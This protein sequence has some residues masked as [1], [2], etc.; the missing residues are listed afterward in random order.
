M[1]EAGKVLEPFAAS[2]WRLNFFG[3]SAVRRQ[4]SLD[5]HAAS[6]EGLFTPRRTSGKS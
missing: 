5:P 2:W 6:A 3:A 4:D 1:R